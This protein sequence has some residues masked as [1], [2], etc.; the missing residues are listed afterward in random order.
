MHRLRL[1]ALSTLF[2]QRHQRHRARSS[3]ANAVAQWLR[4]SDAS[5][6]KR[7][8]RA[9]RVGPEGIGHT[10]N[11]AVEPDPARHVG[12]AGGLFRCG[13]V[14]GGTLPASRLFLWAEQRPGMKMMMCLL[15]A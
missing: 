15:P 14:G 4:V 1:R 7:F 5:P 11:F 3:A 12:E 9:C 6:A 13:L 2:L 10:L 8:G